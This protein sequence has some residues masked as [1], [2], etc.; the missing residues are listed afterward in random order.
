MMITIV[1]E[2]SAAASQWQ[3]GHCKGEVVVVTVLMMMMMMIMTMLPIMMMMIMLMLML[4]LMMMRDL[5]AK[6]G[7]V[8]EEVKKGVNC[9]VLRAGWRHVPDHQKFW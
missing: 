2:H 4:M 9:I 8:S 6:E 5:I 1:V 3:K 7:D